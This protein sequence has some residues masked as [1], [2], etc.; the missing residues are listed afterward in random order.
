MSNVILI[1]EEDEITEILNQQVNYK[2]VNIT[3]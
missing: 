1:I 3:V 2:Y